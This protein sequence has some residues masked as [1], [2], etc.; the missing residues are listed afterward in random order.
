MFPSFLELISPEAES[1]IEKIAEIHMEIKKLEEEHRDDIR[2]NM[3]NR[4]Q[5]FVEKSGANITLLE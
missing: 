5:E 2:Q 3:I 1:Y 4:K